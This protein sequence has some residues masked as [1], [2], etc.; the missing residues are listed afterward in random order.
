M[1]N[2]DASAKPYLSY[3]K[4]ETVGPMNAPSANDD[5]HNPDI[6]PYVSISFGKPY[7][8]R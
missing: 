3:N 5:V 6:N 4:P 8:L 2:N 1:M 7:D